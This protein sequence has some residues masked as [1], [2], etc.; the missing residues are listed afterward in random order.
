MG[1]SP[2]RWR[3]HGDRVW[4]FQN[5]G[6][7]IACVHGKSDPS[8]GV[9]ANTII[10]SPGKIVPTLPPL[11]SGVGVGKGKYFSEKRGKKCGISRPRAVKEW[12]FM[13][14]K[15]LLPAVAA[16]GLCALSGCGPV[17]AK[18]TSMAAIY[19]AT[20][21]LAAILLVGYCLLVRKWQIWFCCCSPPFWW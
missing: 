14:V 8:F 11:P 6:R 20:A 7:P 5:K 13:N 1:R 3:G 9:F 16:A 2:A 19:S 18:S 10:R 15:I 12:F 17:G 4:D 21:V